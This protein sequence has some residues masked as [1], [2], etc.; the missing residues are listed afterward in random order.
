MDEIAYNIINV[1]FTI[2]T[3]TQSIYFLR[4]VVCTRDYVISFLSAADGAHLKYDY[5][6]Y[7]PRQPQ[8]IRNPLC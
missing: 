7:E 8:N 4:N 5:T 6:K 3:W 1:Y 2:I